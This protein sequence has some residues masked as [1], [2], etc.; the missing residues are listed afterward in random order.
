SD[1]KKLSA[2]EIIANSLKEYYSGSIGIAVLDIYEDGCEGKI[3]EVLEAAKTY[4]YHLLVIMI[5]HHHR[6]QTE[7]YFFGNHYGCFPARQSFSRI[8]SRAK[9]LVPYVYG[10]INEE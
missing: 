2:E 7:V 10:K 4:S 8:I 5:S 1:I 3:D 6:Q 9:D